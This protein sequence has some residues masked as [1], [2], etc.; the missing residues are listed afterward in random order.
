MSPSLSP[1]PW[2]AGE[3]VLPPGPPGCP[4]LKKVLRAGGGWRE[5]G[6]AGLVLLNPALARQA[7][8]LVPLPAAR[9]PQGMRWGWGETGWRG[10]A[11][12]CAGTGRLRPVP[13]AGSSRHPPE[14]R[15]SIKRSQVSGATG[16]RVAYGK[17]K[18]SFK[19]QTAA[20]RAPESGGCGWAW[21]SL[22]PRCSPPPP[23]WLCT[24]LGSVLTWFGAMAAFSSSSPCPPSPLETPFPM[25]VACW[26]GRGAE[27]FG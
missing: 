18:C 17:K 10:A 8:H 4:G 15:P 6:G 9:P 3:P 25:S 14:P 19:G 24:F 12:H 21:G 22:A 2:G 11:Y 16:R 1:R 13:I 5:A 23:G 27:G 7:P 26:G 20:G